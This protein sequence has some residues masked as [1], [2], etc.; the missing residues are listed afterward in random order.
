MTQHHRRAVFGVLVTV[1]V[2][3]FVGCRGG[4]SSTRAR[5]EN[6]VASSAPVAIAPP[7]VGVYEVG[8]D[9]AQRRIIDSL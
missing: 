8:T 1:A 6:A 9:L 3:T 5:P 2:T 7:W 4:D